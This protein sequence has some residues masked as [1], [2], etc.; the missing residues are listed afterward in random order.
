MCINRT[1]HYDSTSNVEIHILSLLTSWCK[2]QIK[3]LFKFYIKWT[4]FAKWIYNSAGTGYSFC[5]A[6]RSNETNLIPTFAEY[7]AL[8][9]RGS[10][11]DLHIKSFVGKISA[12]RSRRGRQ[13]LNLLVWFRLSVCCCCC[14][15]VS[16]I[17]DCFAE[18]KLD[19]WLSLIK[20]T[21]TDTNA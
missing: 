7:L 15:L 3:L 6:N 14:Q 17:V 10:V 4:C 19:D 11:S 20:H 13:P 12:N 21:D 16:K 5:L 18:H 9:V 1:A 2:Y 8:S